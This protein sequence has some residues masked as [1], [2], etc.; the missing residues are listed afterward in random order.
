MCAIIT[1]LLDQFLIV[2]ITSNEKEIIR[3]SF[4]SN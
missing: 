2:E 3:T 1:P 4:L